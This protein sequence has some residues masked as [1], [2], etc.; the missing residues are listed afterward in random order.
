M[1]KTENKEGFKRA[2]TVGTLLVLCI[3]FLAATYF[4]TRKPKTQF[5]PAPAATDSATNTWDEQ[6]DPDIV[7]TSM[8]DQNASLVNGSS[9]DNTQE[10][11]T[12]NETNTVTNL[13]GSTKKD[14]DL[15]SKPSEPPTVSVDTSNPDKQ[16]EY[17]ESVPQA[18]KPDSKPDTSTTPPAGNSFGSSGQVYDPVFGWIE[19]GNT[20]QDTV[21]S[22]GSINKQVGSMN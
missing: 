19:T 9:S 20:N 10:I 8:T 17:E 2:L 16:P 21:D 11:I 5:S 18:V 12:E 3:A 13:S 7:E 6:T 1:K 14:E 22:D 15:G 4:I